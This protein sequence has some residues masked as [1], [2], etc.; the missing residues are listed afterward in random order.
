MICKICNPTL[1]GDGYCGEH[2]TGGTSIFMNPI[3]TECTCEL[4]ES[5]PGFAHSSECPKFIDDRPTDAI[6]E[7][8]QKSM[9]EMMICPDCEVSMKTVEVS[10]D[11]PEFA[12]YKCPKCGKFLMA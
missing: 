3:Q 7:A 5:R 6:R 8:Y 1:E 4:N 11:V 2:S 12:V 9:E 10:P